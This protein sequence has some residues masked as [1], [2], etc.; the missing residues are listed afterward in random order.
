MLLQL[1]FHLL[2]PPLPPPL[3]PLPPPPPHP[4]LLFHLLTLIFLLFLH[5]PFRLHLL[6]LVLHLLLPSNPPLWLLLLTRQSFLSWPVCGCWLLNR[7]V[8]WSSSPPSSRPLPH[9]R[10]SPRLL[11]STPPATGSAAREKPPSCPPPRPSRGSLLPFSASVGFVVFSSAGFSFDPQQLYLLIVF[12][13]SLHHLFLPFFL[14]F[15]FLSFSFS[16]L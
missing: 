5:L 16:F 14:S 8:S 9:P 1:Q 6:H 13:S 2:L 12:L 15:P 11:L 3:P 4:L 10:P 7:R